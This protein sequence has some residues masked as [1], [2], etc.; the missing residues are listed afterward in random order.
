[1]QGQVV[2]LG[3]RETLATWRASRQGRRI[4]AVNA[5]AGVYRTKV[6]C[7][8]RNKTGTTSMAAL[9]EHYGFRVG[10]QR[11]VE[12]LLLDLGWTPG[13]RL[14]EFV[15]SHEAF[16]D[17]PFSSSWLL[18]EL[19]ARYPEARYVLTTRDPEAWYA[20]LKNH[21]F[22]Q[23]GLA[24]T[25]SSSDVSSALRADDYVAPGWRYE[26]H[27]RQFGIEREEQLYDR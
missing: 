6:F 18:P 8:G 26:N 19:F 24:P 1:M 13:A 7:I 14:W 2:G 27:C 22:T 9:L 16:Q 20:S 10:P 21:H 11:E 25:A 15:E 4:R 17:V 12:R 3:L 23:M 5:R